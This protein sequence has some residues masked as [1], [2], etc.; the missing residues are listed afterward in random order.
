MWAR[1]WR[2]LIAL[3][4]A[5]NVL[6]F[7]IPMP[8]RTRLGSGRWETLRR[9]WHRLERSS[10]TGWAAAIQALFGSLA[11]GAIFYQLAP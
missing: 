3:D 7:L 1:D 8:Q 11:E 9:H 4:K 10:Q 5:L 2:A 6:C